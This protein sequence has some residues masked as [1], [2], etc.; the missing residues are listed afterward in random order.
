MVIYVA[1]GLSLLVCVKICVCMFFGSYN[2]NI[3]KHSCRYRRV[4]KY[5]PI[6]PQEEVEIQ[7]VGNATKL[8]RFPSEEQPVLLPGSS[9]KNEVSYPTVI[10]KR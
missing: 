4:Q 9:C 1:R 8:L 10:M 3:Y 5:V 7:M 2:I 6:E